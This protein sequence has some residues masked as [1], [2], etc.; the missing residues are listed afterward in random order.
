MESMNIKRN[1]NLK[2]IAMITMLIDHLGHMRMV[3]DAFYTISRT[4]GRIAFPIFAYQIAIGF[5]KTSNRKRYALRLFGFGLIAQIPYIWF[6]PELE[7]NLL[8]FNILFLLLAGLG[9]LQLFE[10]GEQ[11]RQRYR[12]VQ[13]GIDFFIAAGFYFAT[14][15]WIVLPEA[16]TILCLQRG[17]DISFEYSSY[18]LLMILLFYRFRRRPWKMAVAYLAL[19]L[20]GV[21]LT[22][23]WVAVKYGPQLTGGDVGYFQA[24][25]N[26]DLIRGIMTRNLVNFSLT[27]VWFQARSFLSIPIL[28]FFESYRGRFQIH[29]NRAVGYWFYPVHI[30]IL[31][32]ITTFL[33]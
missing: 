1:D 21:G 25:Q 17:I 19:S 9:V 27:G 18:G 31:V 5:E 13:R 28:I 30:G 33:R 12:E 7:R 29:L 4:I 10:W 16:V 6:N 14:L 2:L 11:A 26:W 24:L 15:A 3:G 22:S 20:I 32:A 8:H 23:I